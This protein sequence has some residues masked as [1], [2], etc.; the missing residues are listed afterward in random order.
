MSS[1]YECQ[2]KRYKSGFWDL[3]EKE[4]KGGGA[5]RPGRE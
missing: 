5:D 3:E 4:G 1:L 2:K